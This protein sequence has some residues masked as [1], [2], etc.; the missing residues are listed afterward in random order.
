M[1][2]STSPGS[3][4][5]RPGGDRCVQW[6]AVLGTFVTASADAFD[7]FGLDHLLQRRLHGIADQVHAVTGADTSNRSD[8]ADCDR[9]IGSVLLMC[10]LRARANHADD[11]TRW[12]TLVGYLK[13]HH[14][15]GTLHAG[16]SVVAVMHRH[17]SAGARRAR[18]EPSWL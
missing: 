4:T 1:R 12:W 17:V 9:V 6:H 7:G 3:P 18:C 11:P 2:S 8:T 14:V 10:A 16:R 13:A 15:R 5:G